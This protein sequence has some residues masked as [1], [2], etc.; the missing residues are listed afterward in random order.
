MQQAKGGKLFT[1]QTS[2]A[3]MHISISLRLETN[4]NPK[5]PTDP[6]PIRTSIWLKY[7][8]DD[9][10][11]HCFYDAMDKPAIVFPPNSSVLR[12][13]QNTDMLTRAS[14]LKG[15]HYLA[16]VSDH[17]NTVHGQS[18]SCFE[19]KVTSWSETTLRQ[20][21]QDGC[22]LQLFMFCS[23]PWILFSANLVLY[24]FCIIR[25]PCPLK[26]WSPGHF[27]LSEAPKNVQH[28]TCII[29]IKP[30]FKNLLWTCV[31]SCSRPHFVS[32]KVPC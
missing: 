6:I 8:F 11:S 26:N 18:A 28:C 32:E 3:V 30:F 2:H 13:V 1:Q 4:W 16:E 17:V 24:C 5:R 27:V 14:G 9:L 29:A 19:P 12:S 21:F 7:S 31:Y 22:E 15:H 20:L 25:T 10:V 23:Q